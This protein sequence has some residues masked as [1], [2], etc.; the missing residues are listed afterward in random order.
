MDDEK[1]QEYVYKIVDGTTEIK[2]KDGC[3]ETICLT[4]KEPSIKENLKSIYVY[5]KKLEEAKRLG[6]MTKEEAVEKLISVNLWSKKE[7]EHLE[8]IPERVENLKVELY[9][10]YKNFKS[11]DPI[12][13]KLEKIRE[14]ALSLASKKNLLYE[15]TCEGL[16]DIVKLRYIVCSQAFDENGDRFFKKDEYNDEDNNFVSA[17]I[18]AYIS[19]MITEDKIRKLSQSDAW[20]GLWSV[21]KSENGVFG[22]P[23]VNLTANQK[24]LI[25]WSRIYDAVNES[26]ECPSKTVI[27]DDDMLD[28]WLI[29][30]SRR[31]EKE[32][33]N[34]SGKKDS[35]VKGDEVFL[36]ADNEQDAKRIYE[37]NDSQGKANIK[38]LE[39]QID[40]RDEDGKGLKA[41]RTL[42]AQLEMRQIS[43]EK[44]KQKTRG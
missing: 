11:R 35:N 18:Y 4:V 44:F 42:E 10:A 15:Q 41:Q 14:E 19:N 13:K 23:S 39:K 38:S 21:G 28:G 9:L 8:S 32:R 26:M 31:R 12:R 29:Y 3:C 7:N 40:R 24:S 30:Q 25:T 43:N 1:T 2:L 33:A 16:A 17:I 20:K 36:F 37:L 6:V 27:E 5:N 22:K 34:T